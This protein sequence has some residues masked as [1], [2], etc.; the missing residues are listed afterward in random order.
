MS[1]PKYRYI[2]IDE[3]SE[4]YGTNDLEL[5]ERCGGADGNFLMTDVVTGMTY[6]PFAGAWTVEVKALTEKDAPDGEEEEEEE[7]ED[8]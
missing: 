3:D 5:A 1:D 8:K 2:G 6:S 4:P 7:E